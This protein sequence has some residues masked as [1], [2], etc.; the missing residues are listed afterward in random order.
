MTTC[1]LINKCGGSYS[2]WLSEDHPTVAE[3][4]A[5]RKVCIHSDGD[6]CERS[7]NIKVKNCSFYYIYELLNLGR[8]YTRYCSTD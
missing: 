4:A 3:G 5:Q 2:A 8:C 1:P 6:C 7:V